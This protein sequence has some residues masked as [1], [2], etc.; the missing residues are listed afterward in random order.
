MKRL[1]LTL[2]GLAAAFAASAYD[3]HAKA[4]TPIRE[5]AKPAGKAL[6]LVKGGRCDFSLVY[7]KGDAKEARAARLLEECFEKATGTKPGAGGAYKIEI[8]QAADPLEQSLAVETT[9][10]GV[11]LSGNAWFA[12]LDFAERFLG[13]RWYFPGETGT[14]HP[15]FADLTVE[16]VAYE[17]TP[18]FQ[19]FRGSRYFPYTTVS[20]DEL[21]RHWEPYCGKIDPQSVSRFIDR[22]RMDGRGLEN[23]GCHSPRPE[24]IAKAHP[25]QLKTI[26]YT[27]PSGKFWYNPNGHVGNYYNVLDLKFADML[28]ADWKAFYDS[29]GK[30]DRGGYRDSHGDAYCSFGVCDTYLPLTDVRNDPVVKELGLLRES[31]FSRGKE[32]PMCNVYARFFQYLGNRLKETMPGKKL[33]LLIYYNSLYASLDPRFRLP[34]NIELNV[35]DGRLPGRTRNPEAMKKTLRLFRE[36]YEATGNRPILKAWLY[37]ARFDMLSRAIRPEFVGDVPKV[38]GKYLSREGGLFYDYDGGHDI[39]HY[40][41]SAYASC[42]SQWNPDFD[43]DA[44]VAEMM[45]DLCGKEAGAW[46]AKFHKA[47]KDAYVAYRVMA[48]SGAA[49][50]P[51]PRSVV[52]ELDRCLKEAK[53]CLKPGS[54]EMR[55]YSLIAD[56][57]PKMFDMERTLAAYEPPVYEVKRHE[58]G[59][60]WSKVPDVP[61]VDF[62]TGA[63]QQIASS[64]KLAW[65]EKGLHGRFAAPYAPQADRSKDLWANDGLELFFTPGLKKE[66]IYQFAYDCFDSFFARKQRLLPIPQPSDES[67]KGEAFTSSSKIAKD[68]WTS[69]FFIPWTLFDAGAPRAYDQWNANFV[70]NKL[71]SPAE[72]ASSSFTLGNHSNT[73][74]FGILRFLGKG[75]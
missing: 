52:D 44:A 71:R 19:G 14:I 46:L 58:P 32:A 57:W 74:M 29:K 61:M 59:M 66:V 13:V 28:V 73:P 68:G 24:I 20:S 3:I 54:V 10:D 75:D 55:R 34:D 30:D 63:R 16:P 69:E 72:V 8:V 2:A 22:W 45:S 36:W 11:R 21:R 33:C 41:Y 23:A 18:W 65:D 15:K 47:A 56:F 35:C 6:E 48:P 12:A 38:L 7:D 60:D 4:L 49:A 64:L 42:R 5:K 17:D 9:A 1:I 31:D 37:A 27:S 40:F 39:W 62:K 51:L 43:V 50:E 70:R 53:K 26:F 67:Y 25:D